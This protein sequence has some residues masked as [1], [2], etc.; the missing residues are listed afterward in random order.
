MTEMRRSCIGRPSRSRGRCRR[1][2]AALRAAVVDRRSCSPAVE[3]GQVPGG[4]IRGARAAIRRNRRC[5]AARRNRPSRGSAAAWRR[6]P[7][8]RTALELHGQEI[9]QR[10][11]DLECRAERDRAPAP[12]DARAIIASSTGH[13]VAH[14]ADERG[15][16]VAGQAEHGLA[17]GADAE[18]Q[19]LARALRHLVQHL[20]HAELAQR[21]RARDRSAPSRRRRSARARRAWRGARQGAPRARP[22]SSGRW[23]SAS[24]MEAAQCRAPR[25]ARKCS[26][27]APAS[28]RSARRARR[29]R[30]RS[31]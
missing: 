15:H 11:L 14:Q 12:Q 27:A 26:S 10:R 13:D 5:R 31:R 22:G 30:R 6:G 24:A 23:S 2:E 8:R 28:P 29:V 4:I 25:A 1:A 20:A 19:R 16:R 17:R 3:R 18:P 7:E 9:R 21:R